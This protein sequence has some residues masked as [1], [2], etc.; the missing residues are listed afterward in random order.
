M[1]MNVFYGELIY[2]CV[3]ILYYLWNQFA[4]F[5]KTVSPRLQNACFGLQCF[6][7]SPFCS[8]TDCCWWQYRQ[9]PSPRVASRWLCLIPLIMQVPRGKLRRGK[10]TISRGQGS[11]PKYVWSLAGTIL[12]FD[13]QGQWGQTWLGKAP[14]KRAFPSEDAEYHRTKSDFFIWMPFQCHSTCHSMIYLMP[15]L[16][17]IMPFH[18]ISM[19][20]HAIQ[21]PHA[22]PSGLRLSLWLRA[23]AVA[24]LRGA[25][26][27][28][29]ARERLSHRRR[30]LGQPKRRALALERRSMN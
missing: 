6:I 28:L 15:I 3:C 18:A 13:R 16:L 23:P 10:R 17:H 25:P 14:T 19:P 5:P 29:W 4:S 20:F 11:H 12:T 26:D 7:A 8:R 27:A 21:C 24:S 22:T 30:A 9:L 1:Y 2:M